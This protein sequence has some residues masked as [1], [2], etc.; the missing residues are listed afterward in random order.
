MLLLVEP[1]PWQN[2]FWG[3]TVLQHRDRSVGLSTQ[4]QYLIGWTSLLWCAKA[5]KFWTVR[6]HKVQPRSDSLTGPGKYSTLIIG[7][8]EA[9]LL[10]GFL[11]VPGLSTVDSEADK[12]KSGFILVG[13]VKHWHYS[14]GPWRIFQHNVTGLVLCLTP[15]Q[16]QEASQLCCSP[17]VAAGA[18]TPLQKGFCALRKQ[19]GSV[20]G[21]TAH[22]YTPGIRLD[23][24]LV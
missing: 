19:Q 23:I 6:Q 7:F 3:K 4:G 11:S 13:R 21:H 9:Q 8:S 1:G 12:Q 17:A 14:H 20:R 10:G 15:T 5:I 2:E 24:F 18:V 22:S 16:G